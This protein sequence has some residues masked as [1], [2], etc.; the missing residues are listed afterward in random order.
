MSVSEEMTA[1][2]NQR[3]AEI[4]EESGDLL[5]AIFAAGFDTGYKSGL[6]DPLH[7][8]IADCVGH[9]I[10]A[11]KQHSDVSFADENDAFDMR[12]PVHV[13][14]IDEVGNGTMDVNIEAEESGGSIVMSASAWWTGSGGLA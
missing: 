11:T 10:H 12:F 1:L 14:I 4:M 2:W 3:M 7:I 5:R 6:V 8:S 13:A 9:V